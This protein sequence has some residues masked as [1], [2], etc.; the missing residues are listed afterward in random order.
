MPTI[1]RCKQIERAN[2]G[3][4]DGCGWAVGTVSRAG[5]GE[6]P[7]VL[8]WGLIVSSPQRVRVYP[9]T[10]GE[11][12]RAVAS[13]KRRDKLERTAHQ[14]CKL[15]LFRLKQSGCRALQAPYTTT[16]RTRIARYNALLS[17]FTV[18]NNRTGHVRRSADSRPIRSALLRCALCSLATLCLL[19][20]ASAQQNL[21]TM[22]EPADNALSP[23]EEQQLGAQFMRQ[24]RARL[25]LV[26]DTDIGEYIQSLGER[27]A[28]ASGSGSEA[29]FTFFVI[30]DP[31][32]NAFAIPGG[33]IGVYVGLIDAMVKEEQLAGVLAHE[34]AHVTQRH[35]ARAFATG[36]RASLSTAAAVMAAIL[37]GA[38][39][40][41]AG[42]AALAAGLAATQQRAI[43]FTRANE[44]EADRIGIE[45][46]ANAQFD[47]SAMA[48]SFTILRRKN[49]LNTAGLQLEYL[50]T[51]PLDDN[52]I[53]EA[54]DR[55]NGLPRKPQA[56]AVD[57]ALFKARLSV[58][59]TDDEAA[60]ASAY[61]AR[62]A[63][64]P[65]AESHYAL[66]LLALRGNK[67]DQANNHLNAMQPE[68][69]RHL[70][71]RL[72]R[73]DVLAAQGKDK[74]SVALLEELDAL[75]P[76]RYSVVE[77]R[78]D[79]LQTT[80]RTNAAEDVVNRYLRDVDSPN[81]LAWRNLAAIRQRM[82]DTGGSH[83]ALAHYFDA[84]DEL[85]R[86]QGQLELALRHVPA[87]SQDELRLR[88]SLKALKDR[89]AR[90][91]G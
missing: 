13:H 24:I 35:H 15:L 46:L 14:S 85:E 91:A 87:A 53:A 34:V 41:E 48:E 30:D 77:R 73:S 36:Q 49:N 50:R 37:I 63:R 32:V 9:I 8:P 68:V 72:L 59:T 64:R 81:P 5:S 16:R 33:Y 39:S 7:G 58:L 79:R 86:A 89:I 43:N 62:A 74:A 6:L 47:P 28:Y 83:E 76:G 11:S 26:R 71:V 44:V 19:L 78:L 82:G 10:T 31:A 90:K 88:A 61:S 25:P 69:Q 84:L 21:P 1:Y 56:E 67:L 80:R 22:G 60:L 66:A 45:I 20:P 17:Y 12:D 40:P 38:A 18:N 2:P 3:A 52:R 29:P 65:D 70:A 54:R 42:Q 51:H 55:A 57:Y 27:L 23:I 4:L 75:H